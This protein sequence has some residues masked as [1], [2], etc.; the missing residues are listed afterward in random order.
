MS[1]L[2]SLAA[3]HRTRRH[4]GTVKA[5]SGY[6]C[7]L[8]VTLLIYDSL[9]STPG[10]TEWPSKQRETRHTVCCTEPCLQGLGDFKVACQDNQ[11]V[12]SHARGPW[13][14]ALLGGGRQS[15]V[16]LDCATAFHALATRGTADQSPWDST[17]VPPMT[18]RSA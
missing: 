16:R 17:G 3:E 6:L 7:G 11:V 9:L 5:G 8:L 18:S 12:L 4:L 1:C 15:G 14:P 10:V 2:E 13:V